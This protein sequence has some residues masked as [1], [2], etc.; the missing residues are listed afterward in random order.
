MHANI[1]LHP[2]DTPPL[3]SLIVPFSCI[4]IKK[5]TGSK[6]LRYNY[7]ERKYF[8]HFTNL[9]SSFL[10]VAEIFPSQSEYLAKRTLLAKTACLYPKNKNKVNWQ[11]QVDF[12]IYTKYFKSFWMQ[13]LP[14]INTI[15]IRILFLR[16]AKKSE[17]RARR[18]PVN[19][20]GHFHAPV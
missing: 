7:W 12:K 19:L 9:Q 5:G 18:N 10:P 16:S 8:I 1:I 13:P 6:L 4:V 3:H 14:R 15:P 2:Q 20:V 17:Q 11:S